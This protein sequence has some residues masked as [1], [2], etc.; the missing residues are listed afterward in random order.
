MKRPDS[1]SYDNL[2]Q[3]K[4]ISSVPERQ[5]EQDEPLS[6]NDQLNSEPHLAQ[7]Q[8]I[9]ISQAPIIKHHS[10]FKSDENANQLQTV[11]AT[12]DTI[13]NHKTANTRAL[14]ELS[15][16]QEESKMLLTSGSLHGK[17]TRG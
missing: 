3:P 1:F 16:S 9:G 4:G 13:S 6:E 11:P 14:Q 10:A 2:H 8:Q 7:V 12:F 15:M 17:G 5:Q